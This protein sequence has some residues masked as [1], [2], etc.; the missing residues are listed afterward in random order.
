MQTTSNM[1]HIV[2]SEFRVVAEKNLAES[3]L[4]LEW[5]N[6]LCLFI[7]ENY[8]QG[9]KITKHVQKKLDAAFG[10]GVVR[11]FPGI[12]CYEIQIAGIGG[13]FQ[14]C[15]VTSIWETSGAGMLSLEQ[16]K[17][18]NNGMADYT[19]YVSKKEEGLL[20]LSLLVT[21][22]NEI[23]DTL[24]EFNSAPIL[25]TYPFSRFKISIEDKENYFK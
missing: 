18:Q 6:K 2:E 12:V 24:A 9:V 21:R 3:K 10:A 14:V 16:F 13:N 11:L 8:P 4:R 15:Y 23:M 20:A 25:D 1:K 19:T 5:W 7:A 22:Y 17:E